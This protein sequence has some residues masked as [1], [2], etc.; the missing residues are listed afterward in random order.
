M[1]QPFLVSEFPFGARSTPFAL[2]VR[3]I[4]EDKIQQ[5]LPDKAEAVR[6][7]LGSL[8]C[9]SVWLYANWRMRLQLMQQQPHIKRVLHKRIL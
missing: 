9:N 6:E 3:P 8:V 2:S 1:Q 5:R 4:S 7:S